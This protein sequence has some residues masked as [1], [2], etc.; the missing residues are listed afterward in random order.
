M[1]IQWLFQMVICR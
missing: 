1:F